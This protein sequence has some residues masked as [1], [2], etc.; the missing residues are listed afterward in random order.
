MFIIIVMLSPFS[1]ILPAQ[2]LI[3]VGSPIP[4]SH[5]THLEA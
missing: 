1:R 3:I 4:Q 5:V 2:R